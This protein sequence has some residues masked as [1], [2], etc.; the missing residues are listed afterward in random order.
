MGLK[1]SIK[2]RRRALRE[3]FHESRAVSRLRFRRVSS[4]EWPERTERAG[5]GWE[6]GEGMFRE[7]R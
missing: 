1:Q 7:A 5:G 2:A 6:L 3:S 4:G